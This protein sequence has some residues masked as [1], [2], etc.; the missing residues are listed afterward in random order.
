MNPRE[1]EDAAFDKLADG[2]LRKLDRALAGF[3]PDEVDCY[4]GGDILNLTLPDGTKVIIN[5]HR[6]ARQIWMAAQRRAWHFD[7]DGATSS[8][9]TKDA[10][11]VSALEQVL[12]EALKRT[13]KLQLV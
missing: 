9:R 5:R 13:I 7:Y 4:L 3:D 10:E 12:S 11:L 1:Q 8:W 2:Q 6:A